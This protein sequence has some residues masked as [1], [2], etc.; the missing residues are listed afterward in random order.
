MHAAGLTKEEGRKGVM[1]VQKFSSSLNNKSFRGLLE[2]SWREEERGGEEQARAL[3]RKMSMIQIVEGGEE[4]E[5]E[6]EELK[7]WNYRPYKGKKEKTRLESSSNSFLLFPS[8]GT[9]D[10]GG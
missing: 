8:E 5:E 6:E 1:L 9:A 2:H 10:N 3:K 4:E 7:L